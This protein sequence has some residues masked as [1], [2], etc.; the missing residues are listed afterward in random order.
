MNEKINSLQDFCDMEALQHILRSWSQAANMGVILL[1]ENNET[2]AGPYG[3]PPYCHHI[4]DTE[5]GRLGCMENMAKEEASLL[6]HA[7]LREFTIMVRLPGGRQLGKIICGQTILPGAEAPDFRE[8]AEGFGIPE[9]EEKLR[10][11]YSSI[12]HKAHKEMEAARELL[13]SIIDTFIEK[14]Y[15]KWLSLH[16]KIPTVPF[17]S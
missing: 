8:L 15:S 14:N 17:R 9:D 2:I 5:K 10:E 7:G 13:S 12:T 16:E 4:Y 6:C 1:D 11:G 3:F